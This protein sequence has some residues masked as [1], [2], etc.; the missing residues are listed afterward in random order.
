VISVASFE[1]CRDN[2]CNQFRR[3]HALAVDFT[4]A[5]IVLCKMAIVALHPLFEMNVCV[6]ERLQSGRDRR[7]RFACLLVEPVPFSIVVED[8]SEDPAMA[9]KVGELCGLQLLV[10]FVAADSFQKLF[11]APQS[12]AAAASGLRSKDW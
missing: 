3:R 5:V 7:T 4:V 12:A 6:D 1:R 2:Q 10:E 9:V 8:G 11:V